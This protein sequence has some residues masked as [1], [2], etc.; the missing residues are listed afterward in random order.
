[1]TSWRTEPAEVL[2]RTRALP[3]FE[4]DGGG[5]RRPRPER[6]VQQPGG[7]G[8]AQRGPAELEAGVR[9]QGG[10]APPGQVRD[11]E[12]DGLRAPCGIG[13]LDHL[14]VHRQD[15]A[16]PVGKV[17]GVDAEEGLMQVD[18]VA[19]AGEPRP[20]AGIEEGKARYAF[21]SA[22]CS[23]GDPT[24][25][26]P[27]VPTSPRCTCWPARRP[28]SSTPSVRAASATK[29]SVAAN[30]T[31]D[32]GCSRVRGDRP[33]RSMSRSTGLPSRRRNPA[34]PIGAAARTRAR[35]MSP[36]VNH[37]WRTM[38]RRTIAVGACTIIEASH[39]VR[40]DTAANERYA[41]PF[42][43]E[44][45]RDESFLGCEYPRPWPSCWSARRSRRRCR[46]S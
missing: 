46:S 6:S 13:E 35:P 17:G 3:G 2:R 12:L 9:Q 8:E 38:A 41:L 18:L 20:D 43:Q 29:R 40:L 23:V 11:G 31:S 1:M 5:R 24:S 33:E 37:A 21:S 44:R 19:L 32:S 30:G 16:L 25:R 36:A 4:V 28:R 26:R 42:C 27:K 45:R 7:E 15:R 22:W 10:L 34:K 14:G 39:A